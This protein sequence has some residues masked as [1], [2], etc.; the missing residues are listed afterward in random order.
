M[1]KKRIAFITDTTGYIPEE[2][3]AHPDVYVVPI[4]VISDGKEYQDG[5]DLSSDEL[6]DI[7]RNNKEVPK[8]SQPSAGTFQ[9]LYEKLKQDYDC[10]I[11]VHVSNKLSGTIASS[12]SGSELAEFDV[13]IVDSLSLSYG[14]TTL[15][16]KGLELAEKGGDLKEI[17]N[18]L[19]NAAANSRNL[20]LLGSLEQLYKGGRM[21]G[22]QFLLGN[23][24]QIKPILSPELFILRS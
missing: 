10:A 12:K 1:E 15:I 11:A 17:A 16:Y 5:V 23:V 6:Y 18:E 13:E 21:S 19:R 3:K 4:V 2:L 14:I 7:I 22:A 24:L 8:T 20:I 9:E